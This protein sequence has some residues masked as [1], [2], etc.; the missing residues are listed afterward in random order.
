MCFVVVAVRCPRVALCRTFSRLTDAT[1]WV[2]VAAGAGD[3]RSCGARDRRSATT[4]DTVFRNGKL[5][6]DEPDECRSIAVSGGKIV[7]D[8]DRRT[9]PAWSAPRRR[10]VDLQ[11]VRRSRALSTRTITRPSALIRAY[12]PASDTSS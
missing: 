8:R 12:L 2:R 1:F 9:S 3:A 5:Y 4:A 11:G 6:H 7:A 10:I